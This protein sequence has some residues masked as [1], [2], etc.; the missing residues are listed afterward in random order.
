MAVQF[1]ETSPLSL[2]PEESPSVKAEEQDH[3][4]IKLKTISVGRQEAPCVVRVGTL[5]QCLS[6]EAPTTTIK[7]EPNEG[8]LS[9]GWDT[10]WREFLGDAES[11]HSEQEN[12]QLLEPML[13]PPFEEMVAEGY[14]PREEPLSQ[15]LLGLNGLTQLANSRPDTGE[16]GNSRTMKEEKMEAEESTNVNAQCQRFRQFCYPVAEGPR[17]VYSHLWD[18]CHL[19]LQPERRTKEQILDLLILEQ[20]LTILPMEMQ[21]W[22]KERGAETCAQ[23]VSLAENFLE[24]QQE[25]ESQVEQVPGLLRVVAMNFSNAEPL[26]S[27]GTQRHPGRKVKEEG[28]ETEPWHVSSVDDGPVSNNERKLCDMSL[29]RTSHRELEKKLKGQDELAVQ[30]R[31]QSQKWRNQSNAFQVISYHEI[32]MQQRLHKG[33]RHNRCSVCGK[34]FRNES[35]LIRHW[36]THPGEKP[37][38]CSDCGKIF[39]WISQLDRHRRTHTGERPYKCLECGKTFTWSSHLKSHRRIHTGE[40]PYE[41]SLCNK[42]FLSS[43]GMIRHQRTHTGEK[44]FKCS[45]CSKSFGAK[46]SLVSHQTIHT[47]ERSY[48]CLECGKSFNRSHTLV[49]HQRI[50]DT[51][52]PYKCSECGKSFTLIQHLLRHQRNHTGEKPHQCTDCSKSFLDKSSL[53]KHQR[54]HT[55]EK[56]FACSDRGKSFSQGQHLLRRQIVHTGE[57]F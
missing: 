27:G 33:K 4:G 9:P 14:Q 35:N 57:S 43:S 46:S 40:K 41:C 55:G 25:G 19:W 7:Q 34:N 21:S 51:E 48:Q 26:S 45:D 2:Q 15:S 11:S 20:F 52:K 6:W 12:G 23:A 28:E 13:P 47:G 8:L 16:I 42:T 36:R 38:R 3:V 31:M 54:I 32:A 56:S 30:E 37:Y 49:R 17:E 29:E 1:G 24:E 39:C 44:P 22:V 5:T 53:V 18:L 50:H 10:S